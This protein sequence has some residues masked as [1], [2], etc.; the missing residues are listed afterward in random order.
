MTPN[1]RE[2]TNKR[3][4]S[5]SLA[6]MRNVSKVRRVHDLYGREFGLVI[7]FFT[8]Q[9][10]SLMGELSVKKFAAGQVI[11][12]FDDVP[13]MFFAIIKGGVRHEF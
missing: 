3:R 5:L 7:P 13:T 4:K 11:Y 10:F 2:S 1:Q 12:N 9:F 8:R 6:G